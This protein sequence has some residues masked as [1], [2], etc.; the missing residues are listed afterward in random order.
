MG[1]QLFDSINESKTER[2]ILVQKDGD[3]VCTIV[4]TCHASRF[5]RPGFGIQVYD[6]EEQ[7]CYEAEWG[8]MFDIGFY[9]L[10][11]ELYRRATMASGTFVSL[12]GLRF[13]VH[14]LGHLF[15]FPVQP[16][17]GKFKDYC[18]QLPN[19][20]TT[21]YLES[22]WNITMQRS[23]QHGY[24]DCV[25]TTLTATHVEGGVV[26]DITRTVSVRGTLSSLEQTGDGA[27]YSNLLSQLG[28]EK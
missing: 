11:N 25:V 12:G 24:S 27:Y 15:G 1:I 26:T 18:C 23:L 10:Y 2:T 20:K 22:G 14:E 19:G 9:Q 8:E 28:L 16:D 21:V 5:P 3:N 7:L 4:M 17:N 13:A 6:D